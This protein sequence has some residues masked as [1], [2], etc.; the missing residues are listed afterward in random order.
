MCWFVLYTQV[1]VTTTLQTRFLELVWQFEECLKNKGIPISNII[2]VASDGVYVMTVE[3][4]S[5]VSRFKSCITNLMLL[6]CIC[7]SFTLVSI[8]ACKMLLRSAELILSVAAYVSGSVKRCT[9][10]VETQQYSGESILNDL[11][12]TIIKIF[13]FS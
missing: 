5:F 1:P 9:Q 10:L 3:K 4:N 8:K 12:N 7:H 2:G 11:N 13:F 6:K